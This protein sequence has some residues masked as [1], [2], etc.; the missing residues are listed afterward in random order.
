[1]FG[2]NIV[3]TKEIDALRDEIKGFYD[4]ENQLNEYF[5]AIEFMLKG[6]DIA[7]VK[8]VSRSGIKEAYETCAPL[9]GI[10]NK[11]AKNTGEVSKYL[12]LVRRKDDSVVE[13]TDP[14]VGWVIDLINKPNDR[15]TLAK[16]V[17]GW[18][19]NRV[20][21][22]DAWQ[23][24]PASLGKR[25]TAKE[26]YL[27]PSHT[28][29][30]EKGGLEKPFRGIKVAGFS[31]KEI[32]IGDIIESFNYSLDPDT[33]FGTSPAVAAA[34]YLSIIDNGMARQD[35]AIQNG[36][37]ASIITPKGSDIG[38]K[39]SDAQEV[40]Q[41][42]NSKKNFNKHL[43]FKVPVEVHQLGNTPVD[44][45]IL[46]SHKEA[47]TALCFAYEIP[48]DLYYGQAKYENAKE[49]KK[50]IYEQIAIPLCEEF[51]NDILHH[52]GLS[53]EYEFKVNTDLID[54]LHG[55]PYEVILKMNQSGSFTT[56]EIR[57]TAGFE[58]IEE[59]WANKVRIPMGVQLGDE[60][61]DINEQ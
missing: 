41:K 55:D 25:I 42:F 46:S 33:M 8:G 1:M 3:R 36:G 11:I 2:L 20:L 37:P 28:V 5:K 16:Y 14:K 40:E 53:S 7:P 52:F 59:D 58:Q 30:G 31:K 29:E 44:L 12:E 45:N 24:C 60:T 19:T 23:Y 43:P 47:V 9:Y 13:R 54:V 49:A 50:T 17:S 27:I 22:G 15:Y 6:S 26:L 56:N 61:Y 48:V 35:T 4:S 34:R 38:I 39:P 21:F 51:G 32:P 57:D 18:A 10:V